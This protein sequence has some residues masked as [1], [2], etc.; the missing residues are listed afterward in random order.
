MRSVSKK[1]AIAF[2]LF[3][4]IIVGCVQN[5]SNKKEM[6]HRAKV[7][8]ASQRVRTGNFIETL[9]E[10]NF[11]YIFRIPRRIFHKLVEDLTPL[12]QKRGISTN[13]Q[14][15]GVITPTLCVAVALHYWGAGMIWWRML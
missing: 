5:H 15:M 12:L 8:L 10:D 7:D 4:I 1:K 9:S 13:A 2:A 3:T 14:S 6:L 11:R